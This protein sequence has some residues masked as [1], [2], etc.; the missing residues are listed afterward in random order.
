M[1]LVLKDARQRSHG[2]QRKQ[3]LCRRIEFPREKTENLLRVKPK[4][5][6]ESQNNGDDRTMERL[7]R[8]ATEME[9]IQ[10]WRKSTWTAGAEME[11]WAYLSML[12]P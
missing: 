7:P 12:E 5:Q 4:L 11:G 9:W 10:T 8:K 1:V 6:Y 3:G 2:E